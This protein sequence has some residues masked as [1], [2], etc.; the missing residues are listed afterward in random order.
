MSEVPGEPRT[1]DALVLKPHFADQ[2]PGCV[3]T[4]VVDQDYFIRNVW[5]FVERK[6]NRADKHSQVLGLVV[7]RHDYGHSILPHALS[8][9][10]PGSPAQTGTKLPFVQD[11]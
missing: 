10:R 7:H 8:P 9:F 2:F 11:A 4:A 5:N 3:P 1:P 6:L